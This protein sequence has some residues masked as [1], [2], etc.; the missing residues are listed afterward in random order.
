MGG[1]AGTLTTSPLGVKISYV[2]ARRGQFRLQISRY[3]IAH[4]CSYIFKQTARAL[5]FCLDFGNDIAPPAKVLGTE[6]V[7]HCGG[8][9]GN[10]GVNLY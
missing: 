10:P 6:E 1:K 2:P 8:R 3:E 4:L 5:D 7:K 9:A